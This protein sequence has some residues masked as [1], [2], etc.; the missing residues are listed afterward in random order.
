MSPST[1]A[2]VQCKLLLGLFAVFRGDMT[3]RALSKL[4]YWTTVSQL[5]RTLDISFEAD[6]IPGIPSAESCV[7]PETVEYSRPVMERV[8]FERDIKKARLASVNILFIQNTDF[9]KA[10]LRDFYYEQLDDSYVRH[11][12]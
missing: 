10:A 1:I 6:E 11:D 2:A 9:E 7:E 4:G 5:M 8:D 12:A 3:E